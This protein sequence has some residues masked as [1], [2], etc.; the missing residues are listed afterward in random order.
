MITKQGDEET[1]LTY[2][3]NKKKILTNVSGYARPGELVA[4]MGA[5]GGGKT[6]LLNI[7]ASRVYVSKDSKI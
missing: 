4:I 5:S 1:L 2:S 7:M 3:G 6:S